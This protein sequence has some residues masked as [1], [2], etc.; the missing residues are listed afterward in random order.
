VVSGREAEVFDL[1][2]EHLTHVEIGERLFIS[3][4][5]VESH[6]ASLRRK[7]GM[8]DHRSLVRMAAEFRSLPPV[9]ALPHEVSSFLGRSAE[10][11]EVA[12]AV[13]SS[14]VVSVVGPGGTGKTRLAIRAASDLS[15]GKSVDPVWVDLAAVVAP[16]EVLPALVAALGVVEPGDRTH[17]QVAIDLLRQRDALLVLDNCEQVLDEVAILV[18]RILAACT[19]VTVL[20]TSRSRLAVPH[21]QVVQLGGLTVG[22][23]NNPGAAVALFVE[24]AEVGGARIAASERSRVV[25]VCQALD[26]MPLAIELAA[27]RVVSIGL[28]GVEAGLGDHRRLLVGGARVQTRHRSVSD[29]IWWSYRLL[30]GLDQS[31]LS[32]VSTFRRSFSA[33]DAAVVAVYAGVTERDIR[34]ALGRLAQHSLLEATSTTTCLQYRTLETVR[35]FGI[36]QLRARGDVTAQERHLDW[37]AR[38]VADLDGAEDEL[39]WTAEVDAIADEVRAVL[40]STGEIQDIRLVHDLARQLATLL[41]G[42]GRLTDSQSAFEHAATLADSQTTEAA[43][44][45]LAAAAAKCRLAGRD[46]FCLEQLAADKALAGGDIDLA[47]RCLTGSVQLIARFQGMFDDPPPLQRAHLLLQDA[48]AY[49]AH[50]PLA[51]F[52][53]AATE[54]VLDSNRDLKELED[55]VRRALGSGEPMQASSLLDTITVRHIEDL[56]PVQALEASRRRLDIFGSVSSGPS[57]GPELKDALHM[58]I[59]SAIAAGQLTEANQFAERHA[60]LP[61]LRGEPDHALAEGI[62]PDA[63]AGNWDD[64]IKAGLAFLAGWEQAGQPVAS[65]RGIAPAAL[66]MV[67]GLRGD[68]NERDAWLETLREIQGDN[69]THRTT[70]YCEVFDAIVELHHHRNEDAAHHLAKYRPDHFSGALFWQWHAALTAEAAVLAGHSDADTKIAYATAATEHNPIA[71]ALSRRAR[72]LQD[73]TTE[74]FESI[75]ADLDNL[76]CPYQAAR[77]LSLAGGATAERGTARLRL[78]GATDN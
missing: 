41:F 73:G 75:A 16:R 11:E 47:V 15:G 64:A 24:R 78:L 31:V 36:E 62:A 65:G 74:E 19:S 22:S 48:K 42:R 77:T 43:D 66:A 25:D 30:T 60:H 7:L 52:T 1:V 12:N 57:L 21:E 20:L 61:F 32:R 8:I 14:R 46:A 6:V 23:T 56:H 10:L 54:A 67:H 33:A 39:G 3:V 51:E 44:L 70:G 49:G 5:T 4:R 38:R 34:G 9:S 40:S 18:E 28:D 59:L 35:Q 72:T 55:F 2:G 17:E 63:L 76:G 71:T 58:A 53:L 13:A 26:G 29:T 69:V 50:S 27:A 68:D 37:C 45:T